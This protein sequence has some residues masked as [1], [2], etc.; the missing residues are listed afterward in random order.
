MSR[1]NLPNPRSDQN[2]L[3]VPL[4]Q[5]HAV[6]FCKEKKASANPPLNYFLSIPTYMT[7]ISQHHR[8]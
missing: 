1:V 6:G 2:F 5:I 4:E 3:G 7:M 8:R